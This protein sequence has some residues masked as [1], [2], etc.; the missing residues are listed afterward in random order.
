MICAGTL[1]FQLVSQRRPGSAR[2]TLVGNTILSSAIMTGQLSRGM[3]EMAWALGGLKA[4][5]LQGRQCHSLPF[6]E[7]RAAPG[8]TSTRHLFEAAASYRTCCSSSADPASSSGASAP[9]LPCTNIM[10]MHHPHASDSHARQATSQRHP[11]E[12]QDSTQK[13]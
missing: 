9:M 7:K 6:S 5:H 13:D 4:R 2:L 1:Q 8:Q 10:L 11:M 12:A 3:I